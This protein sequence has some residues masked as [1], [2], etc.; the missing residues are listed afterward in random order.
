[1]HT[2]SE[3]VKAKEETEQN[4]EEKQEKV[5]SADVEREL[6]IIW[7]TGQETVS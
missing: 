6:T 7:Q 3:N 4:G 5:M 2:W 1:M